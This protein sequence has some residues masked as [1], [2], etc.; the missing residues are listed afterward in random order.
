VHGTVQRD[1]PVRYRVSLGEQVLLER[2]LAADVAARSQHESIA[3]PPEGA[4]GARFTFELEGPTG[5]GVFFAPT[6]GPAEV[7]T[8]G[9]RPWGD[10]RPD[11]IVFLADTFRADNMA[12]YG[13]DPALTPALER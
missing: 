11:I 1:R 8:P 9:Q 3:L 13:G 5:Q 10:A 6:I 12:L 7:G 4:A 2:E